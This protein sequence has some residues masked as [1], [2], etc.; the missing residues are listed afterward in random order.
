MSASETY[1]TEREEILYRQ[2]IE[3]WTKD[4]GTPMSVAFRPTPK[5]ERK[6]S[7]DRERAT[8][9]G[10]YQRYVENCG[11]EPKAT[12]GVSVGAVLDAHLALAAEKQSG[13]N[14]AV[15][16]DAGRGGN[17][18]DHASIVFSEIKDSVNQERK[19]HERLSKSLVTDAVTRGVQYPI[20]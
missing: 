18:E 16:D 19:V 4:D 12:W 7:T 13:N 15:E 14:L 9:P 3:V 20:L 2:V 1:V 10:S 11:V 5:D 8:A 17:H 6:L